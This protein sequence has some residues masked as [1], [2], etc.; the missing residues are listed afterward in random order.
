MHGTQVS[1]RK[2]N[3]E[4]GQGLLGSSGEEEGRMGTW[5]FRGQPPASEQEDKARWAPAGQRNSLETAARGWG[6]G[7]TFQISAHLALT[8][9]RAD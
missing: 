4:E 7:S 9:E 6:V 3:Q 5:G 2:Q 8:L 1:R